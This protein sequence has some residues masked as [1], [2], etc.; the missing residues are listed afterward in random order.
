MLFAFRYCIIQLIF[1]YVPYERSIKVEILKRASAG[2]ME[3]SDA[4]VEIEPSPTLTVDVESVVRKQ[5][6]EKINLA[7]REV[8]A[9]CGVTSATVRVVDRGAL[10]C[11]IR[12]RV[13]TAVKRSGGNE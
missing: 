6:G 4:Y 7:V 12:A 2:T 11:V 10:E 1:W 8:L 5:F 3:S 9:E 13:E